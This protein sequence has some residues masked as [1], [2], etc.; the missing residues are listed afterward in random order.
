MNFITPEQQKLIHARSVA[1]SILKMLGL[2][3]KE[4]RDWLDR[5]I[6]VPPDQLAETARR[7]FRKGGAGHE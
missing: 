3:A 2:T 4:R 6:D 1:G 7:E 5:H